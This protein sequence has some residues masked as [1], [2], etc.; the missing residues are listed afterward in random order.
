MS[1]S[2]AALAGEGRRWDTLA[3]QAAQRIDAGSEPV[4]MLQ[5]LTFE[6]AGTPYA[7][8]VECVR[9]IVRIRPITP[10]PRV[11]EDVRL[12]LNESAGLS[13]PQCASAWGRRTSSATS[14]A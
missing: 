8:P 4:E 9:E 7:L 3:R 14:G 13:A 1:Q 2:E 5:L 11:P 10:V 6:L 12:Q